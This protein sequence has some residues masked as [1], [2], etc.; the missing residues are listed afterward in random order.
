[1]AVV[2]FVQFYDVGSRSVHH[3]FEAIFAACFRSEGTLDHGRSAYRESVHRLRRYQL[4][5]GIEGHPEF[6]GCR[7]AVIGHGQLHGNRFPIV[8]GNGFINIHLE[9]G[10]HQIGK[11]HRADPD[12]LIQAV[13]VMIAFRHHPADIVGN[14]GHHMAAFRH[15]PVESHGRGAAGNRFAAG[16]VQAARRQ[17]GSFY[18]GIAHI[19]IIHIEAC[20][21]LA[22]HRGSRIR[23]ILQV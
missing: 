19:F 7:F 20:I 11:I 23:T 5:I 8:H 12:E 13:I 9:A 10:G 3:S 2:G 17:I 18:R 15:L 16:G 4:I 14:D 22:S 1:M 6:S 21:E